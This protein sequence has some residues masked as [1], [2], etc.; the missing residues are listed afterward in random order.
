[1]TND[2]A[3]MRAQHERERDDLMAQHE[4]RVSLLNLRISAMLRAHSSP[5]E[6][7]IRKHISG[8]WLNK[9]GRLAAFVGT[10]GPFART[11]A[12]LHALFPDRI[13]LDDF[14]RSFEGCILTE[15]DKCLLTKM[16][17]RSGDTI[18]TL[19]SRVGLDDSALQDVLHEWVRRHWYPIIVCCVVREKN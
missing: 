3:R 10:P 8:E 2:L 12:V 7:E 14:Q 6:P 18:E 19:A 15:V 9:C 13:K 1:M 4:D 11:C 17:A 5:A 16:F